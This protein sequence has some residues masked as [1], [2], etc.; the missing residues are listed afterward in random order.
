M[1][2][3]TLALLMTLCAA[4]ACDD[5]SAAADPVW[6]KQACASCSM[7]VSDRRYAAELV[8]DAGA[9]VFFDDPGCMATWLA[10]GRGRARRAWVR[11]ESGAWIDARAA[12]YVDGQ[13]SP[14]AFGFA[15]DDRGAAGWADVESA[16]R[17]RATEGS[18][19]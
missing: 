2:L 6:G 18:M 10:E 19:R 17:R 16:A 4:V 9:R 5:G 14:M 8:T 7:L 12:R 13:P 1:R 15:P 3:V 11:S